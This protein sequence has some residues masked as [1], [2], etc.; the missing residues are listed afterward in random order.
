MIETPYIPTEREH[1]PPLAPIDLGKW[2][3]EK[4][5]WAWFEVEEALSQRGLTSPRDLYV[6]GG[7]EHGMDS[8]LHDWLTIQFG[9]FVRDPRFRGLDVARFVRHR[10][11]QNLTKRPTDKP[12]PYRWTEDPN[13]ER[14]FL[15]AVR[16]FCLKA[17]LFESVVWGELVAFIRAKADAKGTL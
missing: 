3:V 7:D 4:M 10:C 9:G 17:D 16:M 8:R 15:R 13:T 1:E 5:L 12:E 14:G 2:T 11:T 6:R